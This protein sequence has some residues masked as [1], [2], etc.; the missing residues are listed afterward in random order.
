[1]TELRERMLT[2]LRLRYYSPKTQ[3]V[4]VD[5]VARFAA[6]F[7]RAP[8][9]LGREEIRRYHTYVVEQRH[10]SPSYVAQLVAA[11]R[12]LYGTTL[13]RDDVLPALP[14][15]RRAQTLPTVLSREEVAQ[16]LRVVRNLKHRA[17]LTTA[18]SAG[19]RVAEL[20]HLRITDID[21]QRM[22]IHVRHAKGQ[23]D[24]F[25][26]LAESL[27]SVLREYWR[28]FRPHE[29]LFPGQDPQRP[30]ADRTAQRVCT[31]AARKAGLRKHVTVHTLRHSFATHLLEAG[32]DLRVIQMLLGHSSLRTTARYL[33]VS[34]HRLQATP[35]PLDLIEKL[36]D[37]E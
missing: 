23:K 16:L 10:C 37:L 34:T 31:V 18:Y 25:V 28:R 20:T 30:L 4:Y 3:K 19:L 5:H 14:Y 2:D 6:F 26:M 27:V 12:F 1:M 24:R 29:W 11:L 9:Q 15:P 22:V 36:T 8:D 21:S 33:H 17:L 7:G 35:S 13:E 32:A